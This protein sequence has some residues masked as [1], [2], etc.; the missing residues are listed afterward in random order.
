VPPAYNMNDNEETQLI[1]HKPRPRLDLSAYQGYNCFHVILR[2]AHNRSIFTCNWN[3]QKMLELLQYASNKYNYL[4]LTYCF[5]PNHLHL[6]MLSQKESDLLDFVK[7][8]KQLSSYHYKQKSG[9]QLWQ[10]SFYDRKLRF[11]EDRPGVAK[12]ILNNPVRW[13]LCVEVSGYR[14]S[15]SFVCSID[16]LISS[17]ILS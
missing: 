5:M 15:G 13:K 1:Q 7:L 9:R 16:D 14:Y 2:T 17:C 3:Y 6:L 4:V 12:Y 11:D 8:F 10:A